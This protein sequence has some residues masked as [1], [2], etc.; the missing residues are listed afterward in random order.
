MKKKTA[1]AKEAPRKLFKSQAHW[2]AWL[3]KNHENQE[4]VWVQ[5]AKKDG[6]AV[7]CT[8]DEALETALCFGWIDGQLKAH[9]EETFV[10]KFTPRRARS[11]WSKVNRAKAE[12][13]IESGRM[14]TPGLKAIER[15][16][17]GG[18]WDSAYDSARTAMVSPDFQDA[19]DSAKG[20]AAFF[21]KLDSANR[22]A[23]LWRI[24]TARGPA[25][26][27]KRIAEIIAMLKK[28]ETFH[29]WTFK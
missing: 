26:R 21:A 28:K 13:L 4:G 12:R 29:P 9:D 20:A 23:M 1:S 8:Y 5:F 25:L 17:E 22:Y 15:A 10:R 24:Q 2:H 18:E 16:R 7:T 11:I 6:G 27:A 14:K 3:E 19:L